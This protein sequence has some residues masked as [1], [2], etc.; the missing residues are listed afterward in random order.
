[1]KLDALKAAAE[2]RYANT[3]IDIDDDN[4]VVLINAL[5]LDEAQRASLA[6]SEKP[7]DDA[8][9]E[10]QLE[11]FRRFIRIV[12]DTPEGAAKLIEEFGEN[13]AYHVECF[14]VWSEETQAGEA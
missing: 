12:A 5:Q 13:L 6:P 7:A 2:T 9:P 1:M 14:R 8:A 10:T 3:P 11:F 4:T